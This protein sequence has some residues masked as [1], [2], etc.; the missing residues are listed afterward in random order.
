SASYR[1][2]GGH[3]KPDCL[4]IGDEELLFRSFVFPAHSARP[5]E[6]HGSRFGLH[7]LMAIA[8][9]LEKNGLERA[10]IVIVLFQRVGRGGGAG[11][12]I[13]SDD[14]LR[15]GNERKRADGEENA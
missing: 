13:T 14:G 11:T 12:Y 15:G 6:V 10:R 8:V 3:V 2:V 1:V 9:S 4:A 5:A 7:T